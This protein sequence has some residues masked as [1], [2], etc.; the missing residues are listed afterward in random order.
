MQRDGMQGADGTETSAFLGKGASL[1][2]TVKFDG[3]ARI[4]GSVEGEITARDSLTIGETAVVK[5]TVSGT[6]VVVHGQV[7]GDVTAKTRLELRAGARITGNISAPTLVIEPG[8]VF[9]GQCSMG[10]GAS[11]IEERPASLA[12]AG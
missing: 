12:V 9:D 7:T 2:G 10:N 8:A 11:R 4:E 1:T 5:A 3:P 6:T